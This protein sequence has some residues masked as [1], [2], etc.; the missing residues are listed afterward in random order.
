ML[1][2]RR[3]IVLDLLLALTWVVAEVG[4]T[5]MCVQVTSWGVD[6]WHFTDCWLNLSSGVNWSGMSRRQASG[7][8]DTRQADS[9]QGTSWGYDKLHWPQISFRCLDAFSRDL[10]DSNQLQPG[11]NTAMIMTSP[12][13]FLVSTLKGILMIRYKSIVFECKSAWKGG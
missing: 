9:M 11:Y 2:Y 6:S 7:S 3:E 1:Y 10:R 13:L 8:K 12:F 5:S 4:K